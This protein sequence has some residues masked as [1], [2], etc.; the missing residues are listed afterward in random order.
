MAEAYVLL[1][2]YSRPPLPLRSCKAGEKTENVFD[3]KR[4][5]V[6]ILHCIGDSIL[7]T[8]SAR[9]PPVSLSHVLELPVECTRAWV[10]TI[11]NIQRV[12]LKH[13]QKDK[14]KQGEKSEGEV[15]LMSDY[16]S[17]KGHF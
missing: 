1:G 14:T 2:Q 6:L 4:L 16:F 10:S 8:I 15:C 17:L 9:V 5:V 3:L 13:F 7:L 12:W 11:D